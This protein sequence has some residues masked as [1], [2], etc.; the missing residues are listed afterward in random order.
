MIKI[1]P[2]QEYAIRMI[3]ALDGFI[4]NPDDIDWSNDILMMVMERPE[5]LRAA[6]AG[7]LYKLQGAQLMRESQKRIKEYQL[8]NHN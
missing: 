1:S 8:C 2:A 5:T 7:Y 3:N 4:E 6:L